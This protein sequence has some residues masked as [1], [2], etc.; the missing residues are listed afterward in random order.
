LL[1]KRIKQLEEGIDSLPPQKRLRIGTRLPVAE[2]SQDMESMG[3]NDLTGFC[4]YEIPSNAILRQHRYLR[5]DVA[6]RHIDCFFQTI[7]IFLPIFDVG[8][9]REKYYALRS[10]FGD[11]R[12]FVLN[13]DSHNRQQFLC[14]LYAVLALGALYD[15]EE[16]D[17]SSWASWYF[18]EAQEIL[19][20]LLGAVNFELVQAAMLMVS[21]SS[22]SEA[23]SFAG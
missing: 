9:F 12:L 22:F 6:D 7:H 2:Q 20:R 16:G 15:D 13:Q 1:G 11:N 21:H 4:D 19:G 5:S 17:N 3:L 10:L 14:L 23:K 8:K 18:A